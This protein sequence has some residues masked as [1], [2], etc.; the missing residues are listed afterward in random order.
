MQT[1][2]HKMLAIYL[3]TQLGINDIPDIYEDMFI[4]GNTEPDINLFT[5][6]HGLGRK[7][8]IRG[9][10][11]ENIRPIMNKMFQRLSEKEDFGLWDY[12]YLGK[13][14]HYVAD[15]FTF[16]HNQVFEGT[17]KKH[18]EYEKELHIT[19][20]NILQKHEW[21]KENTKRRSRF[22][23]IELLHERYLKTA[24]SIENDCCYIL[25][26]A[27]LMANAFLLQEK[28]VT[29]IEPV[30]LNLQWIEKRESRV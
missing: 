13:L 25:Q 1:R 20:T 23:D 21:R 10:N 7:K 8:K 5:Y 14:M 24:G 19:I 17:L 4:I 9:H 15:A 16:P 22:R 6:L 12:Y 11:Y 3:I 28:A 30:S 27:E 26:A 29:T 2:D 18:R